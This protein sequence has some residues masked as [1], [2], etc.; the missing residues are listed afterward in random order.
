MFVAWP[1]DFDG[2]GFGA[3]SAYVERCW[4]SVIGP[5]ALMVIRTAACFLD[6]AR[7]ASIPVDD[8]AATLGVGRGSATNAVVP[9]TLARSERF[10]LE[11]GLPT[12]EVAV[13]TVLPVLSP[14]QLRHGGRLVQAAH[15]LYLESVGVR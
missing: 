3:R 12:G 2:P 15:H 4:C 10:G 7:R 8:L 6:G 5:T 13:R 14:S 9:H 1:K 11:V